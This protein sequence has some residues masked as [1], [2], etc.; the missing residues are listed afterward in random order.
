VRKGLVLVSSHKGLT[1]AVPV[2]AALSAGRAPALAPGAGAAAVLPCVLC[3]LAQTAVDFALVG[4]WV[5]R[6]RRRELARAEA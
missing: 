4:A 6:S 1:V 2:L 3:H 5:A